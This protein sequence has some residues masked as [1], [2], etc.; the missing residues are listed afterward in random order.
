MDPWS[1]QIRSPGQPP[2]RPRETLR[3]GLPHSVL[4][5][6]GIRLHRPG[7]RIASVHQFRLQQ[8]VEDEGRNEP[9]TVGPRGVSSDSHDLQDL[10]EEKVLPIQVH[11]LPIDQLLRRS[12]DKAGHVCPQI[13]PRDVVKVTSLVDSRR[14]GGV[15]A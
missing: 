14:V 12:F 1:E 10:L 11:H 5:R 7:L 9:R 6:A 8:L 3:R 2:G 15:R 13:R 4:R